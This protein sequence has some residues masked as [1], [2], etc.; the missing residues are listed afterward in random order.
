[1]SFHA[2][3]HRKLFDNYISE[4]LGKVYL[5]DDQACDIIIKEDVR[6]QL[7]GSVWKLENVRDVLDL[8]EKLI[9]IGQLTSNGYLMTFTSD[10]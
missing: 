10:K 3:S 7:N 9:F 6:I 2:T 4:I 1:M 8:R 5:G